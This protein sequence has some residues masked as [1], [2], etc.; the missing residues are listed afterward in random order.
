MSRFGTERASVGPTGG[1]SLRGLLHEDRWRGSAKVLARLAVVSFILHVCAC[2]SIEGTYGVPPFYEVY[3]SPTSVD[4]Q[5]GEEVYVRPFFSY[6]KWGRGDGRIDRRRIRSLPPFVDYRLEPEQHRFAVL[7]L[8]YHREKMQPG[9]ADK[10][11]MIFPFL[12]WG[13]DPDGGSYFAFFPVGGKLKALF[14]QD[15]ISFALF[16]LLWSSRNN[17]KRSLHVLFPFYNTVWGGDWSGWRLWPFYGHYVG[18]TREGHPNYDRRFVMWPFYIHRRDQLNVRPSET[19]FTFPFYGQRISSRYRTRTYLWPLFQ[20]HYDLERDRGFYMG[21][22]VPYHIPRERR[23]GEPGATKDA[24]V[25][26]WPFFS[27][28]RETQAPTPLGGP[29]RRYYRHFFLWPIERYE[30]ATDGGQETTRFWLLPLIWHFY[31]IDNDTLRTE[32]KWKI[33]PLL[34]YERDGQDVKLDVLAPLIFRQ[35]PYERHYSRWFG[36]FRY[37]WTPELSGWEVLYGVIMYRRD[38]QR[39]ENVVSI[40]GGLF[41]CGVRERSF[42]FRLLY[43]PWW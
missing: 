1:V 11:W 39:E 14:G 36:L 13:H 41:E 16:P 15:E 23:P 4:A 31:Y 30:W 2:R 26:V 32:K 21:F 10:D 33:W 38:R 27:I 42:V 22:L 7:P 8:F 34:A 17:E 25:A 12:F 37:R 24:H 43:I 18:Q 35:G 5:V 3:D 40:L 29:R 6:E 28:K 19:F 20:T 9:G